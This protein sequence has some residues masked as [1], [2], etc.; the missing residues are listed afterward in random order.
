MRD[1]RLWHRAAG[2]RLTSRGTLTA[3]PG[4]GSLVTTGL[5]V[6]GPVAIWS[7]EA[8]PH[9]ALVAYSG[10]GRIEATAQIERLEVAHPH[11]DLLGD[12]SFLVVGARSEWSESGPELNAI[13]YDRDGRA[14]RRGCL[15]DGIEH[16]QV[17]PDGTIWVGYFDEGVFGNL[18]W[19]GP[20]PP[21]IG[22]AGIAAWTPDLTKTWE[23]DPSEGVVSDCE[24]L[25]VS[26]DGVLSTPYTDHPILQITGGA[27]TTTPTSGI[28]GPSGIVRAG[29]RVGV[30]GTYGDPG[31]VVLG[32]LTPGRFTETGRRHLTGPGG[33]PMPPGRLHCRGAVAHLFADRAW[34]TFD[35]GTMD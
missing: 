11:L 2:I 18:G 28:S 25:N 13:V 6:S 7:T 19:G 26:G 15:G 9:V 14:V 23:L 29:R 8:A 10:D 12:G 32:E 33:E 34:L 5:S 17:A 20:G 24:T 16:V 1:H 4:H 30:I 35:L 27:V 31:L 21:P 3:P 22:S